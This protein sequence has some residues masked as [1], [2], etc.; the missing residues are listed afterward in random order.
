MEQDRYAAAGD[1]RRLG[2]PEELLESGRQ[3]RWALWLVNQANVASA[4]DRDRLGRAFVSLAQLD[5]RETALEKRHE[6]RC[7]DLLER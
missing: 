1:A 3:D 5:R 6:I 4:G 7:R 2:P